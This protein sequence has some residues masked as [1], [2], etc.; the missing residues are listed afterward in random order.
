MVHQVGFRYQTEREKKRV[1]AERIHTRSKYRDRADQGQLLS[2][3]SGCGSLLSIRTE[4]PKKMTRQEDPHD[5]ETGD[6]TPVQVDP[7]KHHGWNRVQ[8][9]PPILLMKDQ[10]LIQEDGQEQ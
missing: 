1:N 9:V 2:L 3:A 5:N 10:D 4:K 6:K 7:E 8:I